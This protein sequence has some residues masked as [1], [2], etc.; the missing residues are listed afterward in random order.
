ME[1]TIMNNPPTPRE[2]QNWAPFCL[3]G[4]IGC[5]EPIAIFVEHLNANGDGT[6][7]LLLG[8]TGT[9][10]SRLVEAY[11]R[12]RNCPHSPG[13]LEGPCG[14]CDICTRFDFDNQDSGIFT[15]RDIDEGEEVIT[16]FFHINCYRFNDAAIAELRKELDSHKGDRCIVYLD[17][18][19][20]LVEGR[21]EML[22]LDL[23]T[24]CEAIWIGTGIDTD[25][26]N[27]MFVRR[28]PTRCKM[29]IPSV[30][31]LALFLVD[32]CKEWSINIDAPGTISLLAERSQQ[33][34]AECIN[35]LA[36]A[37][38]RDGRLLDRDLVEKHPFIT[39]VTRVR[40]A[41]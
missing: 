8:D 15:H 18:V 19:H 5:D 22:L 37:A 13:P 33:I 34:T 21:R 20:C 17:E 25:G 27:P 7:V 2:I 29:T 30:D 41:D 24:H 32:R 11:I 28:F 36:R 40:P 39:G 6:N 16:H 10:K 38:A 1:V 9:G 12:T 35:V 23:L 31:V 26:L 14:V 4:F 3:G